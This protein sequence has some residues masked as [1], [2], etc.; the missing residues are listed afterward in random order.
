MNKQCSTCQAQYEITDADRAMLKKLSPVFN[1]ETVELPAQN[2]CPEC[3]RQR[4]LASPNISE[5]YNRNCDKCQKTM[6]SAYSADKPYT[7]YCN[8]CWWGDSWDSREYGQDYDF[9]KSFF[10]QYRELQL[11]VPRPTLMNKAPE[12]SEY[13]NYAGFNKDCYLAVLGSWY[14]EKCMYGEYFDHS[15]HSLDCYYLKDSQFCYECVWGSNLYNCTYVFDSSD[16]SDCGFSLNLQ[17]CKNCLFCSNLRHKEYHIDN[18]PV[19]KE[20]FEQVRAQ[21]TSHEKFEHFKAKFFEYRNRMARPNVYNI[22]CEDSEGDHLR[23]CKNVHHGFFSS[24]IEDGRYL[25]STEHSKDFMDCTYAGFDGAE[26]LYNCVTAGVGGQRNA[27]SFHNWTCNDVYHCDTVQSCSNLFG[28][29]NM[30][31]KQYCIL[32]KQYSKEGYNTLALKIAK[33][34]MTTGEWGQFFPESTAPF[35]YN[36]TTAQILYPLTE[37]EAKQLGYSWK[38]STQTQEYMGPDVTLPDNIS[39]TTDEICN[40]ILRCSVS[41]RLYKIIPDELA[42][43]RKQQLPVPRKSP[44]QR[45]SERMQFLRTTELYNVKCARCAKDM[46]SVFPPDTHNIVHCESCYLNEVY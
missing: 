40:D 15:H 41:Q 12:N 45:Q 46:Q 16:S 37:S 9:N 18:K 10:T 44:K 14:N 20:T 22:N 35:C 21:F 32:N 25:Y 34:M 24:N 38:S 2:K 28:C 43:Y 6:I 11:K 3:R 27:C 33:H 4:R 26:L 23:G 8:D 17:G 5:F 31:Q 36:E 1:G 30:H 39:A 13:C 42:F 19:D 29:V 7:V